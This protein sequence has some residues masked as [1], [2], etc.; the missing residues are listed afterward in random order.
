M[1]LKLSIFT[2]SQHTFEGM[3]EDERVRIF[4][5]SHWLILALKVAY[6][7]LLGLIPL[8]PIVFFAREIVQ[9]EVVNLALFVLVGYY[10]LL[11]SGLFYETMIYLLDTWIVTDERIIDIFQRGFFLR[12]VSEL[13]LTKVQDI[14]VK[15]NGIIQTFFDFG[16]IEIQSAGTVNKFK[17]RQVS[18]PQFI[19]DLITKIVADAK[20]K[21]G[22][23]VSI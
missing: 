5:Y 7:F 6:Y 9:Y 8:V 17:F 13:D 14:S 18:H 10:A 15:T 12:T 16:D 4:L 2:E 3:R 11:W 19:K 21:S 23:E 20:K 1:S 22:E